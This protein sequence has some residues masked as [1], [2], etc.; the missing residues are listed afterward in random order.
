[1][2]RHIGTACRGVYGGCPGARCSWG[3]PHDHDGACRDSNGDPAA[4][5][6]RHAGAHCD[7]YATSNRHGDAAAYSYGD[8]YA[9]ADPY[10][11]SHG[12]R[13]AYGYAYCDPYTD[14]HIHSNADVYAH[15][16]LYPHADPYTDIYG[17]AVCAELCGVAGAGA[18]R[19]RRAYHRHWIAWY[20]CKRHCRR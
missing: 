16:D 3:R 9:D 20:G 15:S 19:R 4:D 14:A 8:R 2:D 1:M 11:H 12:H 13:D 10:G 17:H 6:Y 18:S 7:R 5:E